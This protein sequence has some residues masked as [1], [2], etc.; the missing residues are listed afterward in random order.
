MSAPFLKPKIMSKNIFQISSEYVEL[1]NQIEEVEGVLTP[2]MEAALEINTKDLEVKSV[3]YL[4]VI[5]KNEAFNIMVDEE[6]K[7]LQALKKRNNTLIGLLKERLVGAIN[8]FGEFQVGTI[9][10]KTRKSTACIIEDEEKI[11]KKWRI[12]KVTESIDKAGIK[13][14]LAD[15]DVP[16]AYLKENKS[17]MI[18]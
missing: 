3:A 14:A 1:M 12:K 7:R 11:P 13:K 4:E 17:L 15:G 8:L 5:K 10:F 6:I 18:K 16:G 9:T 2:E